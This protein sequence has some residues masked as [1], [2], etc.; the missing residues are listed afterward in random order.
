MTYQKCLHSQKVGCPFGAVNECSIEGTMRKTG[1]NEGRKFATTMVEVVPL[2]GNSRIAC[3]LHHL[4][5]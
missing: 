1:Q 2:S 5:K 4:R 3:N